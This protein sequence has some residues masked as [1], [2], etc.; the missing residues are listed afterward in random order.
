M[1]SLQFFAYPEYRQLKRDRTLA[2]SSGRTQESNLRAFR[3][4]R[5]EVRWFPGD[6]GNASCRGARERQEHVIGPLRRRCS[7]GRL[8]AICNPGLRSSRRRSLR[9]PNHPFQA[10][11]ERPHIA[12]RSILTP[13]PA[14]IP[15]IDLRSARAI[16]VSEAP[17]RS[18]KKASIWSSLSR[19]ITFPVAASS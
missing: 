17:H 9:C 1:S 15:G 12:R 8:V 4:T 19:R 13:R 18:A 6:D 16:S 11:T 10:V 7:D 3:P 5:R 14:E 2:A